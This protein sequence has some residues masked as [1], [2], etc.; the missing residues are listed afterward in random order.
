M[1]KMLRMA[2]YRGQNPVFV[3]LSLRLIMP[4]AMFAVAVL[5]VFFIIQLEQPFFLKLAIVLV[6]GLCSAITRRPST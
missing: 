1:V 3:F 6:R 4:V 2:G 5:Y